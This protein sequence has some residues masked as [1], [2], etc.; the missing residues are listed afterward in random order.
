MS[1]SVA[2]LSLCSL[3]TVCKHYLIASLIGQ[4]QLGFYFLLSSTVLNVACSI[5]RCVRRGRLQVLNG[6]V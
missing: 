2:A 3:S 4:L 6:N 1:N 5:V